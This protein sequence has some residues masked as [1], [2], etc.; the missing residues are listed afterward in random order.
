MLENAFKHKDCIAQVLFIMLGG[1]YRVRKQK[2]LHLKIFEVP[3]K[4]LGVV[5]SF[6]ES[7]TV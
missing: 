1:G 6:Y 3:V 7:F 4:I 5:L 2:I